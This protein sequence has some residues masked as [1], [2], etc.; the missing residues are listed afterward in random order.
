MRIVPVGEGSIFKMK[1]NSSMFRVLFGFAK[2]TTNILPLIVHL[3]DLGNVRPER[4]EKMRFQLT[5]S[6]TKPLSRPAC[7][8]HDIV[9]LL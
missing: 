6:P 2:G 7:R 5:S 3:I 4:L 9:E 8:P 1:Q